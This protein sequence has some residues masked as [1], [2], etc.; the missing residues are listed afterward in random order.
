M[1]CRV[2]P[3]Q[4]QPD[5]IDTCT[6]THRIKILNKKRKN[7]CGLNKFNGYESVIPRYHWA[8]RLFDTHGAILYSNKG[9]INFTIQTN[10]SLLK[11]ALLALNNFFPG[12]LVLS[13]F[14]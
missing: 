3:C 10:Y 4:S 9:I 13:E 2:C 6:L 12:Q 11:I 8:K 1:L 14:T 7:G 5:V